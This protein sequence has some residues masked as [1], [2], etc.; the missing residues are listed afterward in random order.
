MVT[1]IGAPFRTPR[2]AERSLRYSLLVPDGNVGQ[3]LA[4]IRKNGGVYFRKSDK[5]GAHWFL[6]WPPAAIKISS[7]P[8]TSGKAGNRGNAKNAGTSANGSQ[9]S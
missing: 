3:S 6:P 5:Q 2:G 9:P 8:A 4:T 7:A 1:L